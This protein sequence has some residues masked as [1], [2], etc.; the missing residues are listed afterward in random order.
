VIASVASTFLIGFF[1]HISL[2][3]SNGR[4]FIGCD[5]PIALAVCWTTV[6]LIAFII[7]QAGIIAQVHYL[8]TRLS[9]P[10]SILYLCFRVFSTVYFIHGQWKA[11]KIFQNSSITA[12]TTSPNITGRR[13]GYIAFAN[14]LNITLT[15]MIAARWYKVDHGWALVLWSG[16]LLLLTTMM[17]ILA[18]P[19]PFSRKDILARLR[20]SLSGNK[21]I[22][23]NESNSVL[24]GRAHSGTFMVINEDR[25][26]NQQ[27]TTPELSPTRQLSEEIISSENQISPAPSNLQSRESASKSIHGNDSNSVRLDRAQSG[28]FMV[29]QASA[30]I[31]LESTAPPRPTD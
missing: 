22:R 11:M 1:Y 9:V 13:L 28:T 3:R 16:I 21:A 20:K 5:V 8:D 25:T 18:I 27:T 2:I 14:L 7:T 4:R 19:S 23:K 24:H 30:D 29:I 15:V 26:T 6:C 10:A 31:E 17:E 12:G